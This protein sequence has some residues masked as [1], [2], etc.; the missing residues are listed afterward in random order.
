MSLRF[1]NRRKIHLT[2]LDITSSVVLGRYYRKESGMLSLFR[3]L[4]P[5]STGSPLV[6]AFSKWKLIRIRR[7]R[8]AAL[9]RLAVHRSAAS[10]DLL[11]ESCEPIWKP[12]IHEPEPN[13]GG[14]GGFYWFWHT[15]ALFQSVMLA[16]ACR[17]L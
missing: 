7:W 1:S 17:S 9:S 14:G 13:S 15:L 4:S 12:F 10:C 16:R 5:L 6:I 8:V 2:I 11:R 3:E